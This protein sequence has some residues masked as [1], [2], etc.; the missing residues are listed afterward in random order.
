MNARSVL[1]TGAAGYVGSLTLDALRGHEREIERIVALDVREVPATLQSGGIE[2]VV[3]DIT[4][5]D[6]E[7]LLRERGVDTVVHLA[8]VVRIPPGAG[9]DFAY[10]VDVVGTKR[11]IDACVA[12]GV[13]RLVVTSSGAAYG[14]HADNP[15]W[16]DE[17]A[18]LRGN[19]GIPYSRHKRLVE[20]MLAACR[21]EHSEISQLVLRAGTIIGEGTRSPVTDLFEG[22]VV[23]GVAGSD[24]PFVFIWDR[25]LVAVILLGVLS[26]RQGVYNLAGGGAM[27][28]RRIAKR[29]G[30][31]YVPVPA[32][33]LKSA[34]WT[35]HAVGRSTRGP[36]YVDFLRY[37]PV[38][39]NRR[40]VE[41]LGYHPIDS[42]AA[43]EI[44]AHTRSR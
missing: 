40:L 28:P 15:A 7:S 29:L 14:Y 4:E 9:E 8:S 5:M 25:D 18:P 27:S 37:R 38:L 1:V 3:G 10:R 30:K 34:L 17:D 36:E 20:E 12:A 35:L 42:A 16:I 2:H 33:V 43:F 26:D 6:L 31:T 44:W 21:R 22:P 19:E 41:E 13:S 11:V 39:S 32:V 24:S 23:L